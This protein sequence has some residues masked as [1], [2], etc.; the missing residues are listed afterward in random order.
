MVRDPC[1]VPSAVPVTHSPQPG[2]AVNAPLFLWPEPLPPSRS[3]VL[4]SRALSRRP[5]RRGAG[6]RAALLGAGGRPSVPPIFLLASVDLGWESL[7]SR[8][9]RGGGGQRIVSS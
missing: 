6:L 7:G 9:A 8:T 4:R 3:I 1:A 2:A 5:R